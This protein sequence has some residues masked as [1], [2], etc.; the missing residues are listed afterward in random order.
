VRTVSSEIRFG[1]GIAQGF[2]TLGLLKGLTRPGIV[3]QV[4]RLR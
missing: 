4:Q 2:A 3:N 1:I